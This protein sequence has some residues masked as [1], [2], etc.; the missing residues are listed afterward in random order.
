MARQLCVLDQ[1]PLS[2]RDSERIYFENNESSWVEMITVIIWRHG[3]GRSKCIRRVYIPALQSLEKVLSIQIVP[4]IPWIHGVHE[5]YLVTGPL[6]QSLLSD[7]STATLRPL[8]Q[9]RLQ[10]P[11]K[12]TFS[13]SE[14]RNN[15]DQAYD[16]LVE[17]DPCVEDGRD[18]V[19]E[20]RK[21][22]QAVARNEASSRRL[23]R[24]DFNLN[25]SNMPRSYKPSRYVIIKST[26]L[27]S[28]DRVR[29]AT[30]A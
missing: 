23:A 3:V 6:S 20:K 25:F 5:L 16:E 4:S 10:R 13:A 2:S 9:L 14:S 8:S 19:T 21:Q 11:A 27:L 17:C 15:Q 1:F 30:V 24:I 29:W 7:D 12:S 26:L 22:R 18:V 28:I